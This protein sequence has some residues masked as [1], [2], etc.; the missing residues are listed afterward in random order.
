MRGAFQ[1]ADTACMRGRRLRLSR[2]ARALGDLWLVAALALLWLGDD[3][4]PVTVLPLASLAVVLGA[5]GTRQRQRVA[6]DRLQL[7]RQIDAL[8]L[9]TVAFDRNAHVL[10]W[11]RAA[12]ELFGWRRSEVVGRKNPTVPA[13]REAE[14]AALLKRVVGGEVLRGVEVT[15]LARDGREL[16]LALFTAP[17]EAGRTSGFLAL[18]DDIA[19]RRRVERE[20][21]QA[22]RRFRGLVEALPLVTYVDMVDDD[23]T[24]VYTSPQVVEL[25]G[26]TAEEWAA[27]PKMFAEL[28]HPDDRARVMAEVHECNRTHRTFES[29]YRMLHRDGHYV[30]VRDRSSIVEDAAGEEFARGFLLDITE[31]KRL[32]EQLLQAQKMDA[33]GQ[34]AGGIAHDFNNLLTGISG[35]A[36]LAS[37]AAEPGSTLARCLDGIRS[38]AAEAASLTAR[39]LAFSRRDVP[40]Q[41]I[42]DLNEIVRS[43]AELLSRLVREDVAVRL[44]LAPSPPTVSGDPAQLKQVVLNLALN[45]RDAIA[46]G[47]TLAL[48]TSVHGETVVLRVR[49][50][51]CGMDD[52]TRTRALEP[53]FTTKTAGQG[54]GLGL[55]VVY[56][57]VDGLGGSIGIE[58]APGEGTVVE[59]RLP[60]AGA[61]AAAT[62]PA[63]GDDH[64]LSGIER[65]LVVEDRDVVRELARDLLEA[66]GFSVETACT[67]SDALGLAGAEPFDV[68]VS[69]VVMPG[70][71]GPELA[72][73]LRLDRPGLPVLYMSGYTDDVLDADALDE[74]L[75]RFLR[76][77]FT[78]T[79][80]VGAVRGLLDD[81]LLG[82]RGGDA[83]AQLLAPRGRHA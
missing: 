71:S 66:A 74:P 23:A 56:G 14:S 11:N 39:L 34:F 81:A 63:A 75:T 41:Q 2:V 33:L 42:V 19:E 59:I 55:A 30:W 22:E 13:E 45:A 24:N 46:G 7:A 28:V 83:P 78:R 21:D 79:E 44:E 5:V 62:E 9:A 72:R 1:G 27:N 54:T 65:V 31:Q 3:L 26:W 37:P 29:D 36:D 38:A 52:A 80:L 25:L 35:Y 57:V 8:P 50:D 32:Y 73:A 67:G 70:L 18:Y 20:R 77:P 49:D 40:V 60:A 43:T 68:V 12:E 16:E 82:E 51:G 17:F 47:G 15:R 4:K 64:A 69:D 48:E 6:A 58:S 10:T 53:F 61:P 76:K